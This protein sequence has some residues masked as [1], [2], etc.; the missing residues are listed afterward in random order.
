M[1]EVNTSTVIEPGANTQQTGNQQPTGGA[2]QNQQMNNQ[3]NQNPNASN[4]DKK[5]SDADLDKIINQKFADWQTKKD[6]EIDEAKKLA[7]MN[8]AQ[9]EKYEREKLEKQLADL[10]KQ[11][12]LSEMTKT[13]RGILSESDIT[14][15]D[16]LL[17]V[18]VSTDAEKTNAAVTSFADMFKKAVEKSVKEA[19][20]G[21]PPK[22]GTGKSSAMT[23][24]QIMSIK[25]PVERQKMMIQ[26]KEMFGL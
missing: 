14:V 7:A 20:K 2:N 3:Q 5:Y 16:D 19:L 6:A 23:K 17:A 12:T 26:N 15:S 11:N 22:A 18:L 13:A 21:N 4:D 1:G 24:E 10:T 9:K 8:E 25:D